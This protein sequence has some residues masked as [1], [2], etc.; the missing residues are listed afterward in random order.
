MFVGEHLRLKPCNFFAHS[1][2]LLDAHAQRG[3]AI[4]SC[5]RC[6]IDVNGHV[7]HTSQRIPVTAAV[8]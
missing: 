6:S 1:T 4:L 7:H 5:P 2:C 3:T 8:P